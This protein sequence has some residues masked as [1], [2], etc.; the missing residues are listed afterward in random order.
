MN[1]LDEP[2]LRNI[3]TA[4]WDGVANGMVTGRASVMIGAGFSRNAVPTSTGLSSGST[5]PGWSELTYE[6][7]KE[8]FSS[9]SD[10]QRLDEAIQSASST[11]GS[12]RI[13]DEYQAWKGRGKLDAL[14]RRAVPDDDFDPGPLHDLALRLPWADILTTNFDT[15]L[16]RAAA[17]QVDKSFSNVRTQ[18]DIPGAQRPR[19]V[20][21]HGSFPD[22]R[23][24]IITEDDF[25]TYERNHP[26]MVNLV[27][28]CF[29][30][31]TCCLIGFSG[32]D[33]NFLRWTGWVRDVLG[34]SHMEPIY[35]VGLFDHS[36]ARRALLEARHVRSIDLAPLFPRKDWP[37]VAVR[38]QAST[39]WFLRALLN[40]RPPNYDAWPSG[41][42]EASTIS[43]FEGSPELPMS[44]VE[45]LRSEFR[46]PTHLRLPEDNDLAISSIDGYEGL[47]EEEQISQSQRSLE[48]VAARSQGSALLARIDSIIS[49]WKH[50]RA[51]YPG[52]LVLP[53]HNRNALEIDTVDW[54]APIVQALPNVERA[55]GIKWLLQLQWRLDKCLLPWPTELIEAVSD[56]VGLKSRPLVETGLDWSQ[57]EIEIAVQLLRAYRE[58]G[59]QDDFERVSE[60]LSGRVSGASEKACFYAHQMA[61]ASLEAWNIER[62][63]SV[64]GAWNVDQ[65]DP[66]WRARKAVLLGEIGDAHAAN[67][68]FQALREIQAIK[69]RNNVAARTREAE[70]VWLAS[71]LT[72]WLSD[73][74][75][76]LDERRRF[77]RERGFSSASFQERL[78]SIVAAS[79]PSFLERPTRLKIGEPSAVEAAYILRRYAEDTAFRS[80]FSCRLVKPPHRQMVAI[81]NAIRARVDMSPS[82]SKALN[83]SAMRLSEVLTPSD[84]LAGMRSEDCAITSCSV[85]GLEPLVSKP[86]IGCSTMAGT[87]SKIVWSSQ[88]DRSRPTVFSIRSQVCH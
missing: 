2:N 10:K 58:K 84:G 30:E 87:R 51:R 55:R 64:L 16:E 81:R 59:R 29:V 67:E 37:D 45:P 28:Q 70:I 47:P 4:L 61:L 7:A 50:N 34:P 21:L 26:A 20:K 48:A 78:S 46:D 42:E 73:H 41:L 11:S 27:Q 22:S 49:V 88:A 14:L 80:L 53:W 12:L 18:L 75:R 69:G 54:I 66:I 8:L 5:F 44:D 71:V 24:F 83:N 72:P 15:L 39:E 56:F 40:L 17:R 76:D 65:V 52:W 35:L 77:L 63:E 82:A 25:R 13:A 31:N 23:P 9:P 68:A 38:H 1:F 74:R 43:N 86:T 3:A 79:P 32:E 62:A 6:M 36:P 57:S 19:I 85:A 60:L 33:P